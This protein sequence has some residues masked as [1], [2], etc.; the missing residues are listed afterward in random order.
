MCITAKIDVNSVME[1]ETKC[2]FKM[3]ISACQNIC[4]YKQGDNNMQKLI[5]RKSVRKVLHKILLHEERSEI[6]KYLTK[7]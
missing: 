5:T 3:S 6:E 1:T 7:D 2:F 4:N